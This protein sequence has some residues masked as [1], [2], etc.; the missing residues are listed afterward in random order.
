MWLHCVEF[1]KR[2]PEQAVVPPICQEGPT[3]S[4]RDLDSLAVYVY[5]S[6]P[7]MIHIYIP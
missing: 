7:D 4:P 1:W 5:S 2:E 3:K 6:N